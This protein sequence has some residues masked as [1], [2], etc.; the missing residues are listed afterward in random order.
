M[1][2]STTVSATSAKFPTHE[3]YMAK[4]MEDI[5][6]EEDDEDGTLLAFLIETTEE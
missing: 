5:E 3:A 2:F 6:D 4:V 1:I